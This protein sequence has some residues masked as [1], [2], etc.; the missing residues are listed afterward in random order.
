MK[1]GIG[2][3]R[4]GRDAA[5]RNASGEPREARCAYA[6]YKVI[7][8]ANL[9]DLKRIKYRVRF[10]VTSKNQVSTTK[11][12]GA[13]TSCLIDAFGTKNCISHKFVYK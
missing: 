9:D 6:S 12:R 13:Y 7:L 5:R 10:I 4:P 1:D 2:D 8:L 11:R 3:K